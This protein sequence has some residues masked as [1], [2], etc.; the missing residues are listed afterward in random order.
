MI[1][2]R[3][4]EVKEQQV[5]DYGSQKTTIRWLITRENEGAPHFAMRRFEIQPGGLIGIHHH[6]QE[7][8][9]YF[10]YGEGEVYNGKETVKVQKDDVIYVPPN[11]PHGYKNTGTEPLVFI[12]V[13][14]YLD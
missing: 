6:P 2:K 5:I 14:P 12:C 3:Y 10:L 9:I 4:T 8:E 13:I 7:H 1:K 11:E